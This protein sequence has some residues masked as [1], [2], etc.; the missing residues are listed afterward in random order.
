MPQTQ[1]HQRD[2]TLKVNTP[3]ESG[4]D[5]VQY[6][7]II[8]PGGGSTLTN[9]AP[10]KFSVTE[11]PT[12]LNIKASKDE[13]FAKRPYAFKVSFPTEPVSP[14][15]QELSRHWLRK[16]FSGSSIHEHI[17]V[18]TVE[19]VGFE[20]ATELAHKLHW[21]CERPARELKEMI[22]SY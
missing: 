19:T 17:F 9:S 7:S 16:N 5:T 10:A 3:P 6:S 2:C 13:D 14:H 4:S 22:D 20:A 11:P 8:D 15:L 18:L 12:V 21:Q 1:H